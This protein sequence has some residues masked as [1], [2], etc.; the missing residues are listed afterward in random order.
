MPSF[1][2][3]LTIRR[4]RHPPQNDTTGL[5]IWAGEELSDDPH[6]FESVH[7]EHLTEWCPVV[8]PYLQ[9]PPGWRCLL[10]PGVEDVW[11]DPTLL[12]VT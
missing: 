12:N 8:I 2:S 1:L 9:L 6:Y 11:E 10:A 5:Y 4:Y 7:V 3:L